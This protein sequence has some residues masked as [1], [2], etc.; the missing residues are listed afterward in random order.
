MDQNSS[1]TSSATSS[2]GN[3]LVNQ[4]LQ[5]L[6]QD[7]LGDLL[8]KLSP[9]LKNAGTQLTA[10]YNKL[11]TTQKIVGGALLVAGVTYL[12]RR[13]AASKTG[14]SSQADT[15][16][17]LLY[18][19]NDRIEGY[20]RAVDESTDPE[21]SGYYKQ[22]VS[23]SQLFANELNKA[24]R[25][26]GGEQQTSTTMKGKL[27]RSWMDVKAAVTGS[28]EKAILGSN[29][30]GEEWAIKAYE[31]ALSDNTLSGSLRQ[32]VQRQ[33]ATSKKTY[34]RL[35]KLEAKH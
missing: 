24:L 8:S 16:N 11:S 14:S 27:Y 23:Q 28:D 9:S 29:V 3:P 13:G 2:T 7:N 21:L 18:F 1:N 22:L 30:Y 26:Q 20:Q 6:N 4:A 10:R 5:W 31:D 12:S 32:A 35:K 15:L 34:D 25:E 17:E 19:V 33:Y